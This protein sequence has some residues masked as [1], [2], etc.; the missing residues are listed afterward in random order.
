MTACGSTRRTGRRAAAANIAQTGCAGAVQP[1]VV[2]VTDSQLWSHPSGSRHLQ[3]P[4][5]GCS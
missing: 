4:S 5:R 2:A 1:A 3:T